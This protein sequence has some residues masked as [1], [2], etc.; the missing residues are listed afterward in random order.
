MSSIIPVTVIEHPLRILS[1]TYRVSISCLS[2]YL[3][4]PHSTCLTA[5]HFLYSDEMDSQLAVVPSTNKEVRS[6]LVDAL[7]SG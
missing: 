3:L 1:V 4:S 2:I 7:D 5:L 6:E